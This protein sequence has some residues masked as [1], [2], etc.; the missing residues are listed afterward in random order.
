[1]S[2]KNLLVIAHSYSTFI[3]DQIEALSPS[4]EEIFVFVRL[5]PFAELSKI[6]PINWMK[7]FAQSI[8]IDL[9]NKPSN[10]HVIP[11]PILYF[12]FDFCYKKLGERHYRIVDHII[13]KEKITFDLIHAHV[14][15]SAG[16][17]GARLKEKYT[18]PL[19]LTA[20][21]YDI[22]SL[23]FKDAAWKKN[24]EYVLNTADTIITVSRSNLE[25]IRKLDVET[26]VHVIPNGFCSHLFLPKD[27]A[28]CRRVLNLP[29]DCKIL[30][31]VG[32][33]APLKGHK[34][35]ISAVNEIMSE[36]GDILCIIVGLGRESRSLQMQ[37]RSLGL[38][39][40]VMLVG[41]KR[42]DE[43]PLWMNAC[44][45]VIL[46]SLSEGNPTVLPE[47]LSCGKPFVGTRVGGVPEI[48]TSDKLG[49]LVEPA[50]P[51]DLA[52]KILIA[53]SREWDHEAILAYAKRF[54][55]E[56]IAREII[57]VYMNVSG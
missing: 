57:G 36:R 38:E 18:V 32:N 9:F 13:K 17:V 28:E 25:Y 49:L 26:P 2:Q 35:L 22:Y 37:I 6:I 44:D 23:P 48:I 51:E 27:I 29:Q 34:Y 11:T 40:H 42:H 46:P 3:K 43:I 53:L 56:N 33:L 16:Y 54:T 14:A 30:L 21:G 41:W 24:I 15:W 39:E 10:V 1:M 7:P 19:V 5:N 55:W 8:K 50:D 31:T 4:F 45:L 52:K 47:A 20:H 12:P